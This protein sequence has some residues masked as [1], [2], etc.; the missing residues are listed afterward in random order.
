MIPFLSLGALVLGL[1]T[2]AMAKSQVT[3]ETSWE[4]VSSNIKGLIW[5]TTLLNPVI[6]GI[7]L[8]YSLFRTLPLVAKKA[9]RISLISLCVWIAA[10]YALYVVYGT[11]PY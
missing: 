9:N 10:W 8:Y 1:I 7:T 2:A 5:F 4:A 11:L 3:A 6:G